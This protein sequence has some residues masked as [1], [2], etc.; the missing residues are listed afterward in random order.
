MVKPICAAISNGV[1]SSLQVGAT[2][3]TGT[4]G[5]VA[6]SPVASQLINQPA[7]T[8][9]G[10]NSLNGVHYVSQWC[11]TPGTLDDT[12]F[13]KAIADIVANGPTGSSGRRMGSLEVSPGVYTF[14]STVTV[15]LGIN[16]SIQGAAQDSLWGAFIK[17][18]S[19]HPNLFTVLAD[20]VTIQN[21]TFQGD[22][23]EDAIV[24]G[25]TSHPL[26][27]THINW[28]WFNSFSRGI[29][30]V[31]GGGLDL[32]HNT[33]EYNTFGIASFY[34]SGDVRAQDIVAT[35]LRSYNNSN[36]AVSLSGDGTA[37]NFGNNQFAGI[38]DWNGGSGF[39]QITLYGV[40]DTQVSGNFN[41]G[42]QDDLLVW[43]AS[44]NILIGPIVAYNSG[45]NTITANSVTNLT[46]ANVSAHNTN[47]NNS[48]GITAVVNAG[49]IAGLTASGVTST[50]DT[51]K[52]LATYGIYVDATST[53]VDVHGNQPTAQT[54]AAYD[55]LSSGGG[56]IVLNALTVENDSV[57]GTTKIGVLGQIRVTHPK[58]LAVMMSPATNTLTLQGMQ[59]GVGFNQTLALNPLG[60]SVTVNTKAICLADGTNCGI[61][62]G[63]PSSSSATCSQGQTEFD[64]AYLYTC[65]A[66]NTW[67]RVATSNF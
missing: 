19:S 3:P 62:F 47:V 31:N 57:T 59:S 22:V 9:V 36:G 37:A 26:Y 41:N 53:S 42:Y 21:I 32:S 27:D 50:A 16:I 4:A 44:K 51:G 10:V 5:G 7:G 20:S 13:S 39:P 18:G 34:P 11:T 6:F 33:F 46:V 14:N 38:F 24:L 29:H 40:T 15:P 61:A 17:A 49:N 64:A 54:T 2:G 12:C 66:A 67:R 43:G 55:V 45:R 35:D 48:V 52:G 56:T 28:C 25:S 8:T 30:I 23:N 58:Q 63:T 65:V 1:I 60:G